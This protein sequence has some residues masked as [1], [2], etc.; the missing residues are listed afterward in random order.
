MK[1]I[2]FVIPVF[3]NEQ[4]IDILFNKIKSLFDDVLAIYDYEFVFVDDG[5]DDNSLAELLKLKSVFS[6]IKIISFSRNFGQ[7]AALNAG[8]RDARGDIVISL[9]A[10]LQ[11]PIDLI[12]QMI[13]N[14]EMGN[15]I[16]IC[17]RVNRNDGFIRNSTSKFFYKLIKLSNPLMPTGGFDFLLLGQKALPEFN[18]LNQKN[19]FFQGDVLWLGFSVKFIPYER[20]ERIHGKSQWSLSKRIK[21]FIDGILNTAYWPIRLMSFLGFLFAF[22]G[23]IYALIV[24][25]ARFVNETPF[26]GYAPIVIL[27]LIIGGLIMMM[28]GIM[29]EYLWRIYDETKQ[30]PPYIIKEKYEN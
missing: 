18:R 28:L 1:K 4:S 9:S 16:V 17:Y 15:E 7:T 10:D 27:L 23:F 29:G 24:A 21:Y 5:S 8:F 20:L 12:P 6:K 11:E 2:S 13:Q 19:K 26:K 25:Y 22:G 30:R 3:R 14:W